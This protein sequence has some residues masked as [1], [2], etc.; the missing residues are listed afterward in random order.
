M[1]RISEVYLS[2][3]STLMKPYG[4]ERYFVALVYLGNRNEK[5]TQKELA[6]ALKIDKVMAMRM[7]DYLSDK[8]L[9][10]REQDCNDRRCQ[11]LIV[12]KKGME[13]LPKVK[14]GIQQANELLLEGF[15]SSEKSQ[16]KQSM[17]K[18]YLTIRSLPDP[19]FIVQAFKRNKK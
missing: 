6:E 5:T 8:G 17:D 16:F 10:K 1:A 12:T 11:N 7:V 3:L 4:I 2:T 14:E 9:L 19:E 18:I 15:S 13:L